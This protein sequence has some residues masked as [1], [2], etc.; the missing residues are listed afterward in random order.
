MISV[1]SRTVTAPPEATAKA[2][3][4][5]PD[6]TVNPAPVGLSPVEARVTTAAPLEADS[7]I[8][9]DAAEIS[10]ATSVTATEKVVEAVLE[11]A[12]VAVTTT[13]HA[14]AVSKSRFVF[15]STVT[16]PEDDPTLN[17]LA[18]DCEAIV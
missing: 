2:P 6:D 18:Q 3:L 5:F 1:V 11:S 15:E 14:V 7:A 8:V 12:L 13:V 16:I 17:A 9:A 10:I 4:S